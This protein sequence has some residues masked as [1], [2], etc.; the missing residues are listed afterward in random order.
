MKINLLANAGKSGDSADDRKRKPSDS[1]SR[2]YRP[3]TFR[4]E[5]MDHHVSGLSVIGCVLLAISSLACALSLIAPFWLLFP[6]PAVP[7]GSGQMRTQANGSTGI[8]SRATVPPASLLPDLVA[9]PP[10]PPPRA[11]TGN[12]SLRVSAGV[13]GSGHASAGRG[14]RRPGATRPPA[15]SDAWSEGLWAKCY[16]VDHRC[17]WFWKDN[18]VVQSSFESQYRLNASIFS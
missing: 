7:V 13:S 6:V 1:S 14:G 11:S 10:P 3:M 2:R 4:V 12:S 9:A 17:E 5:S 18:F 15:I 16:L 8:K